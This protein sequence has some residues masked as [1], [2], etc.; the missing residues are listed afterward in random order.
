MT[1]K[2]RIIF[3]VTPLVIGGLALGFW[4]WRQS[5]LTK[6][7]K[8]STA[9]IEMGLAAGDFVAARSALSG[10]YDPTL[11]AEKEKSVRVAELEKAISIRD[12]SVIRMAL[13]DPQ[14]ATLDP[15]LLESADLKLARDALQRR[16]LSAYDAFPLKWKDKAA[17]P[18]QWLLLQA[19]ALLARKLPEEAL[20]LLRSATLTGTDDAQ[21]Y[22]RIA[23]LEAKEPWKA[24]ASLDQGLKSD[25]RNADI[26][27]FRAQ[28]QESAGRIANARLDY[29]AA[30]LCERTNPLY[31]DILA[32]FYLRTEDISAAAETWRDAA[33][34]T[35]LGVYAL[36]SWFWSS[37]SGHRLSKP[38]PPC[39]Q[40]GWREWVSAVSKLP[41]GVFWNASLDGAISGIRGGTNR[42]EVTWMRLLESLRSKDFAGARKKIETG[43]N[44]EADDLNP[45]LA[46]KILSHLNARENIDPRLSLA[47]RDLP[48]TD[49]DAHPFV[50]EYAKW[51]NRSLSPEENQLFETWLAQPEALVSILFSSSWSGAAV[52]IGGGDKLAV[53]NPPAWFDYGYAKSLQLRDGKVPAKQWLQSLSKRSPASELFLGEILLTSG[54]TDQGL[55]I[56]N[57]I[58]SENSELASR[59]AWTLALTEL[60]RGQP[61]KAREVLLKVPALTATTSGKEILARIALAEGSRAETLRIYQELGDLSADGMIFMSKEA[62]S[63]GDYD[64]ALKWT[65]ILARRFPD[66]PDFRKNILK[67]EEAKKLK[68][69]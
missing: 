43:F 33:E 19:D 22:I 57:K 28:I 38:L 7:S 65:G 41:D 15:H 1:R 4:F 53:T 13:S 63:L 60:D 39:R 2:L 32:N 44:K 52:I 24:M 25:P 30:V 54:A 17:F 14:A 46:L 49:K 8:Q 62:Y 10:I 9:A 36:K 51:A 50:F 68:K 16:D 55:E 69:P 47:G 56:L 66:Q 40:E 34:D 67:I 5:V 59:A 42:P 37:V 3:I 31:R 12:T 21:R 23:L 48:I 26:L 18:G 58:A 6:R 11:R 35:S 20:T 29:V 64:Q 27:A 61:A 45:G